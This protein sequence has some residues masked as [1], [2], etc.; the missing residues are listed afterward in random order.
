MFDALRV[1][2]SA[3]LA[4]ADPRAQSYLH[5]KTRLAR[6]KALPCRVLFFAGQTLCVTEREYSPDDFHR[7]LK[8]HTVRER[9]KSSCE[10]QAAGFQRLEQLAAAD[11]EYTGKVLF[12]NDNIVPAPIILLVDVVR[13]LVLLDEVGFEYQSFEY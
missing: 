11:D 6:G 3:H 13:G 8:L 7:L 10:L 12:C 1:F 4:R 2:A 5:A 9:A